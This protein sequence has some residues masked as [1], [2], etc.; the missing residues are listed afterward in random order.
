MIHYG[1]NPLENNSSCIRFIEEINDIRFDE[2][3]IR[4]D[5]YKRRKHI[6]GCGNM[7]HLH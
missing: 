4:Y 5:K 6:N 3:P 7:W 1:I 2:E